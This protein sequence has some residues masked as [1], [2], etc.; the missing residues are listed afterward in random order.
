MKI[1]GLTN[2]GRDKKAGS[3]LRENGTIPH[4]KSKGGKPT[5][6]VNSLESDREKLGDKKNKQYEDCEPWNLGEPTVWGGGKEPG[7]PAKRGMTRAETTTKGRVGGKRRK[8]DAGGVELASTNKKKRGERKKGKTQHKQNDRKKVGRVKT[9]NEWSKSGRRHGG[10]ALEQVAKVNRHTQKGLR[11][12]K[13][14]K[15]ECSHSDNRKRPGPMK[16]GQKGE[17]E[18]ERHAR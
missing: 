5:G 17:G 1:R 2:L 8:K 14:G 6:G 13:W 10:V 11:G 12:K 4:K 7:V 9:A 15:A 16:G 18:G 3:F